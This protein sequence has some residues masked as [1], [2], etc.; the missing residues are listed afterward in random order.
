LVDNG[1]RLPSAFDNRPLRFEEFQQKINQ[2]IFTSATPASFERDS[3]SQ[4]VEQIIRPTGLVDPELEV[5][6][7]KTQVKNV[8]SE[9]ASAVSKKGRV[10]VT[11][12]T[13]KMAEDLSEFLREQKIKSK[14]LHSG[15]DTISRIK[16]LEELR[17]GNFDVLVGVNLLREGLDLPE[18]TLVAILDADKEGF[19]RSE[20]SLIQTIG[21]AARNVSGK[22][23]LYA[24]NLTGS[25]E[26]AMGET[27]RRRKLQTAYN[28]R[29]KITP[30]TIRKNIE[31]IV[32]HEL[33]PKITRDFST[34]ETL[35]DINGYIKQR[36]KEMRDAAR[37]LEFERAAVIRDEIGELRKLQLR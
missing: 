19:L 35:E 30:K 21:R 16:I 18:V 31:S 3:A 27:N 14:Y 25:M 2:V 6:P 22:V 28:S 13:K 37:N 36:E 12:L 17:R 34:L 26:R 4:V 1:F 8:I 7:A 9:I 32:D 11:T 15:V 33:K 10:L 5:R 20:T 24:D 29:H 23:I